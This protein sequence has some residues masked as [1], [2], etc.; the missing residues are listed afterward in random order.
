[1]EEQILQM[2]NSTSLMPKYD[3]QP[4]VYGSRFNYE[5][6][7]KGDTMLKQRERDDLNIFSR[8]QKKILTDRK[9]QVRKLTEE[10][11][12]GLGES[13]IQKRKASV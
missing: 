6:K 3:L 9:S 11:Q 12:F 7:H 13:F 4:P 2:V 5:I 1:M 8:L 10:N